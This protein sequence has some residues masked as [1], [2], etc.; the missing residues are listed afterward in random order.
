MIMQAVPTKTPTTE[1][2][3]SESFVDDD[4]LLVADAEVAS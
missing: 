2:P 4:A 1:T 3:T